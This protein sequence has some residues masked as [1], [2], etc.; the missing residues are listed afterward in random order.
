M[1]GL[2]PKSPMTSLN[3]ADFKASAIPTKKGMNK[4]LLNRSPKL[5]DEIKPVN[6][7]FLLPTRE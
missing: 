1:G 3:Q 7:I 2:P 4:L 6:I 5:S